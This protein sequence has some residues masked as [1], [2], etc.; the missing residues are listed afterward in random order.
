[1]SLKNKVGRHGTIMLCWQEGIYLVLLNN[2]EFER[3]HNLLAA[4]RCY[5]TLE[6]RIG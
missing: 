3:Y 2:M 1:M 4:I 5:E 6:R